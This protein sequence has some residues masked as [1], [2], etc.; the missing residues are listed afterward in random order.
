MKARGSARVCLFIGTL[1]VALVLASPFVFSVLSLINRAELAFDYLMTAE[2]GFLALIALVPLLMGTFL[3]KSPY[4]LCVIS[5]ALLVISLVTLM[6]L[7]DPPII[8]AVLVLVL[9]NLSLILLLL[10]GFLSLK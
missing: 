8:W 9:Y 4:L 3:S 10:H 2:L 6:L 5:S 7:S 1:L